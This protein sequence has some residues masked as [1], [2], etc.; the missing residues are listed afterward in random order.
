MKEYKY[1]F[2]LAFFLFTLA[3]IERLG[4]GLFFLAV[5]VI[6]IGVFRW[7]S[8]NWEEHEK[9]ETKKKEKQLERFERLARIGKKPKSKKKQPRDFH[10]RFRKYNKGGA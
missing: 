1:W 10:G 5:L 3:F 7:V 4:R 6:A 8:D 2:G 9:M